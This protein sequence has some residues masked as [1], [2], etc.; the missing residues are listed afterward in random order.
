MFINQSITTYSK[1]ACAGFHVALPAAKIRQASPYRHLPLSYTRL[2]ISLPIQRTTL[3]YS[4]IKFRARYYAAKAS[5]RMAGEN[6]QR[7]A[8]SAA[9]RDSSNINLDRPVSRELLRAL[10]I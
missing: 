4:A 9:E 6:S 7:H 5:P 1:T 3:I 8:R 10:R 2:S